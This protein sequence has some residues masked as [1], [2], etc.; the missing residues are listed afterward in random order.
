M[1][2]LS[3]EIYNF[4]DA[5]DRMG[6]IASISSDLKFINVSK[7][8]T[9]LFGYQDEDVVGRSIQFLNHSDGGTLPELQMIRHLY[10]GGTWIGDIICRHKDG[11]PLEVR[12]TIAPS[13][14]DGGVI[15]GY[16]AQ[17]QKSYIN[18]VAFDLDD[19]LY[20]YRSGFNKIAG[21]AI[22][23]STGEIH[24]VNDLFEEQFGYSRQDVIGKHIGLLTRNPTLT[25]MP[26]NIWDV[27]SKGEVYTGEIENY[28]QDGQSVFTRITVAPAASDA[29]S[30]V[31]ASFD[32]FLVI[33]QDITREV[34]MRNNQHELA[35]EAAKQQM[36]NGAIHNISNLQQGVMAANSKTILASQGLEGAMKVASEHYKSLTTLE[37]KNSF[38]DAMSSIIQTSVAQ[39]VE[40]VKEERRAI[41]ETV[42]VVNSFR[43]EQK[44]IRLVND[45][46]ISAFVQRMLNTFSLQAA[47]HNIAV[48]ISSMVDCQV[49]WPTAQVHQIIF[50]LLI[51]AQ[52][53]IC[54]QVDSCKLPAHRG[55]IELAILEEEGDILFFV[56]DNGGG[57]DVPTQ[58]L[59]TP[60]FTTKSAGSGIG[61]HTSA[62][63]AHSMGGTL[64]AENSELNRQRG[65][66]FLLRIPSLIEAKGS[67]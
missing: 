35:V 59:F 15:A 55:R 47:R 50:N 7:N 64:T 9:R 40:S 53:A 63:M 38:M 10:S 56:K 30:E 34:E 3:D 33:Y 67:A 13:M 4:R 49:R 54:E 46:S 61:L 22:V 12:L 45:E 6:S 42:A 60:R 37:D 28:R 57:F 51:N 58:Q 48:S 27:V 31:I 1:T 39:I 36:L 66:Q 25:E 26:A 43:R 32:T 23:S 20:R 8:F 2:K 14:E 24:E 19:V 41:D 65:A 5:I 21:L 29:N 44:N 17:Y 11:F 16:I 18:P 52:Q 62:I